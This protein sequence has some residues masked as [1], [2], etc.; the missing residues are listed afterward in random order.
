ML[1]HVPKFSYLCKITGNGDEI[2]TEV[3]KH[4]NVFY[5]RNQQKICAK[6]QKEDEKGTKEFKSSV[7]LT[8]P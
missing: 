5:T 3:I 6:K 1:N 7:L 4:H 2:C 8:L